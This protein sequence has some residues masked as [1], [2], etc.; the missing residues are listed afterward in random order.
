M[1]ERQAVLLYAAIYINH[2]H[3]ITKDTSSPIYL[4]CRLNSSV[5]LNKQSIQAIFPQTVTYT[6]S[7]ASLQL[8]PVI[9]LIWLKG[10][11]RVCLFNNNPY[12]LFSLLFLSDS[13]RG[14][15]FMPLHSNSSTP[16]SRHKQPIQAI[17]PQQYYISI[18]I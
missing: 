13:E 12:R 8:I 2:G 17:F 9:H 15:L 14:L 1:I 10:Q 6:V 18:D 16:V 5:F 7:Y 11:Y 3:T 4:C